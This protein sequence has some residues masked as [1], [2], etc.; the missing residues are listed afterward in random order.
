MKIYNRYLF[1][2]LAAL[3]VFTAVNA[4]IFIYCLLQEYQFAQITA[5]FI[6]L[7]AGFGNE[8]KRRINNQIPNPYRN[9]K[10]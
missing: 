2:T 9:G 4:V 3:A 8:S 5:M 10:R 7:V 1:A 6:L